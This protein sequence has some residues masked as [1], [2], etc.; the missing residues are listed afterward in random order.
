MN[1]AFK[2]FITD[3]FLLQ[4]EAARELY[5]DYAKQL[6]IIDYHNHLS[7]ADIARNRT[8]E[9]IS[10][11]WLHGDHYKWRAMRANGV[12]EKY[13]TGDA[14]PFEKF[15]K[16]AETVPLTMRNPL[17]HWTHLEML[18]YFQIEDL[19]HADNARVIFNR[20]NSTLTD[21][22]HS[23]LDLLEIM[24]VEALCTTEDPTDSLE[25]HRNF[26]NQNIRM[27]MSTAFRPD[28]VLSI[29]SHHFQTYMI[30][31]GISADIEIKDFK[32]LKDALVSRLDFFHENGSRL[33]DHGLSHMPFATASDHE[34]SS[35]FERGLTGSAVS[36]EE[37]EKYQTTLLTF[38][39]KEYHR[40]GWVQQFH[41]GALRNTN[42]RMFKS[43]GPDTG[44]DSIGDWNQAEKLSQFLDNLDSTNQLAKTILYNLNPRD[45]E[46]FATMTGN[47]ND[48]TIAGKV[49]YG[50]AWWFLDQLDGMEK[51]MNTISNLGMLSQFVG[52]VTDSRSFLSFPRHEYFRRL[53]CNLFG[54]DIDA[55][56]LPF[57][58][59][60]IGQLVTRICYQNATSYFDF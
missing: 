56:L 23:V 45:N 18:R 33:S 22:Q 43:L 7:P 29:D 59:P 41:I 10:E 1:T 44:W 52:M 24:N 49:Q 30:Q 20:M 6:P 13:I 31:L 5:H 47:Y 50:A 8:F 28:R 37:R 4:T 14:S 9:N 12:A 27:K 48:G 36:N 26:G 53:L 15:Q 35:I 16:W 38:L 19:L 60:W 51:Q 34:V 46:V 40:M 21:G 57:D 58:I 17:Y 11:V 42:T 55:G 25:H 3:D 32:T 39:S 2:S 54:N